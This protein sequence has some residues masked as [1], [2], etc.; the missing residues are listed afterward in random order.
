M[1]NKLKSSFTLAFNTY[2]CDKKR[3]RTKLNK[4]KKKEKEIQLKR[5]LWLVLNTRSEQF[6]VLTF[7]YLN[8]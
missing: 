6:H 4:K 2:F 5:S 8:H 3:K 1:M 7:T